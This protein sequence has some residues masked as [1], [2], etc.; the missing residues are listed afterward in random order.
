MSYTYPYHPKGMYFFLL[1][2]L[3]VDLGISEIVIQHTEIYSKITLGE[4]DPII[5][6]PIYDV[7]NVSF[8][9]YHHRG[10]SHLSHDSCHDFI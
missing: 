10:K 5:D 3:R 2:L 8:F 6:K 1:T 7:G 4:S 9:Q